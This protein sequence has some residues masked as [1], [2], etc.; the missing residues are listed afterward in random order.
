[1]FLCLHLCAA[2]VR[3]EAKRAQTAVMFCWVG[4]G[5]SSRT[6]ELLGLGCSV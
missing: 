1:M 3:S 2:S 6:E 5:R 4:G